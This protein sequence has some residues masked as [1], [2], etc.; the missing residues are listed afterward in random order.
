MIGMAKTSIRNAPTIG[1]IKYALLEGPYFAVI[2]D[3]FAIAFGVAPI[4]CP[5]NPPTITAAS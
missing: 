3:I 1:T 4:P 5:M 2:V